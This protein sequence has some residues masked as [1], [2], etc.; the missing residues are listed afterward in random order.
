MERVPLARIG[1]RPVR[2]QGFCKDCRER[3]TRRQIQP[4][5]ASHSH[6]PPPAPAPAFRTTAS[7]LQSPPTP[8]NGLAL[9]APRPR[10]TRLLNHPPAQWKPVA[11][12]LIITS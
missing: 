10:D 8:S 5:T 2:L 12:Y 11:S 4:T 7:E 9:P 3:S 6:P 1:S